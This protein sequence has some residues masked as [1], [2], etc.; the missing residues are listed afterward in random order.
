MTVLKRKSVKGP[1][2]HA[3]EGAEHMGNGLQES[4]MIRK[5]VIL[6]DLNYVSYEI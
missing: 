4:W 2:H 1:W 3:I 5:M 6:G